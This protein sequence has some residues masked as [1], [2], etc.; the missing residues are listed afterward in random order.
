MSLTLYIDNQE[1]LPLKFTKGKTFSSIKSQHLPYGDYACTLNGH[2]IP[3][4]VERKSLGDLFGTMGK[5]NRRFK[6]EC[7]RAKADKVELV[8]VVEASYT[9]V[10]QGY[11]YSRIPGK[12]IKKTLA[13]FQAEHGVRTWFF[14]TRTESKNWIEHQFAAWERKKK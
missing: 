6:R 11:K 14:N 4:V 7:E 10:G 3:W 5:G 12:V 9:E 1:K 2:R 8:V 13:T